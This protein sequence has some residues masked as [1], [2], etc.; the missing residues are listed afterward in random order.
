M[1]GA[2]A[3]ELLHTLA[4]GGPGAVEPDARRARRDAQ[5]FGGRRRGRILQFHHLEKPT[6]V[7]GQRAEEG[8]DARADLGLELGRRLLGKLERRRSVD[9]AC[10]RGA[11]ASVVDD[12]VAQ[13]P[14]DPGYDPLV[15]PQTV[16]ASESLEHGGLE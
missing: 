9:R 11:M 12:H 10:R 13:D 8:A 4:Q 2:G 16:R 5:H 14:V 15:V 1:T 3:A 7:R 6:L